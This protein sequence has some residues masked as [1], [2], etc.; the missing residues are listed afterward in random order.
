L[1]NIALPCLCDL[2]NLKNN[3][4]SFRYLN[5]EDIHRVKTIAFDEK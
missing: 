2:V 4:Y 1:D 3:E 5:I